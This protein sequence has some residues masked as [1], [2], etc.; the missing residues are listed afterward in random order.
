MKSFQYALKQILPVLLPYIFVGIAFGILITEAGYPAYWATLTALF[1]YAGSM[2]IVMVPLMI[3]GV[4]LYMI[5][6]MTLVINGR[7]IFYGLGFIEKFRRMGARYPYMILTLTDETYSVMCSA[8]YPEHVEEHKAN[9]Y[10]ALL[11]HLLWIFSCT[12]GALIGELLPINM[13]GIEFSAAAFFITVCVNQWRQF[14]SHIPAIAALGSA[15]AFIALLG[16]ERFLIPSLFFS[17]SLLLVFK[18]QV[19]KQMG[20][21]SYGN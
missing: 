6:L 16:T 7:H 4:S 12:A 10:I 3:S 19:S 8:E 14:E 15:M 20:V 1:I 17:L 9:F 11:S 5:A 2:Q 13:A 21:T 18:K